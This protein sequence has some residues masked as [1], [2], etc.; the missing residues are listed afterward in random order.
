MSL[1]HDTFP[2]SCSQLAAQKYRWT[3]FSCISGRGLEAAGWVGGAAYSIQEECGYGDS[4]T[5][6][7]SARRITSTKMMPEY[8][9]VR[10]RNVKGIG[11]V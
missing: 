3:M 9:E 4:V 8:A 10:G 7:A 11:C 5:K 2:I 1:V 6:L